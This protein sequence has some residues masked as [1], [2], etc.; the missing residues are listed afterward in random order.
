MYDVITVGSSTID[1]FA[2]VESELI[3][4]KTIHHEHELIAYPCGSKILI[5]SLDFLTGGGG[6]NTAVAL[7]KLGL[8][9]A[10]LGKTGHGSNSNLIIKKLEDEKVEFIGVKSS[11]HHSGY[12]IILDSLEGDRTI[13]AYKGSNNYLDY[14]EINL[15]KLKTKWFYFSS[16][17]D[18][19]F[20]TIEKLAVFAKENDIKIAF[21]PSN[22]LADKGY[23]FLKEILARTDVLILNKEEAILL[24]GKLEINDLIKRL[25]ELGPK[26]VLITDG[27][28]G[29]YSIHNNNLLHVL[30]NDIKPIE[31]TGAGDAFASTFLAGIIKDKTVHESMQMALKNAESVIMHPGAKNGLLTYK[32]L[33]AELKKNSPKITKSK[34]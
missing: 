31:T 4:I 25:M 12:S 34:P 5:K 15:K 28:R 24:G 9:V 26:Q 29:A 22:Y 11:D 14:N 6:T 13:L 2:R 16:M 1:V 20:E 30:P 27:K 32:E 18:K 7:S 3:K 23:L 19:S 33:M 21:N 17:V 8:K 10:Y